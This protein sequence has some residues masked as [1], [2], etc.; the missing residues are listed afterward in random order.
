VNV[1][2]DVTHEVEGGCRVV[3]AAGPFPRATSIDWARVGAI[4]VSSSNASVRANQPSPSARYGLRTPGAWS[5]SKR[6][7]ELAVAVA[8]QES[9]PWGAVVEV[10]ELVTGLLGDPGFSG[11][12]GDP[13]DVYAATVALNHHEDVE[14]A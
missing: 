1:E 12:G 4:A 10:H 13:G 3:R 6:G 11:V 9:E 8:D 7:G 14:A 5:T 2:E